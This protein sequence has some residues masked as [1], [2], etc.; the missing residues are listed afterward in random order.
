MPRRWTP[1][2][3][4]DTL[5]SFWLRNR[6]GATILSIGPKTYRLRIELV[7]LLELAVTL[8]LPVLMFQLAG[9]N[10]PDLRVWINRVADNG[11]TAMPQPLVIA[12][13][14]FLGVSLATSISDYQTRIREIRAAGR[15]IAVA[16]PEDAPGPDMVEMVKAILRV[17]GPLSPVQIRHRVE[18]GGCW[19]RPRWLSPIG[20]AQILRPGGRLAKWLGEWKPGWPYSVPERQYVPEEVPVEVTEDSMPM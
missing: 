16:H 17:E 5:H 10:W 20:V 4:H 3:R 1:P 12:A 15:W 6:R 18:I 7:G 2:N 19:G 13:V 11:W 9:G 8:G 14:T